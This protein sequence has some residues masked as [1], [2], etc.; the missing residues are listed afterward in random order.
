MWTKRRTL[1]G[2]S[3]AWLNPT[4]A[5]TGTGLRKESSPRPS[6]PKRYVTRRLHVKHFPQSFIVVLVD[7]VENLQR[8]EHQA[9]AMDR[10][11]VD[12]AKVA[13][14]VGGE[15]CLAFRLFDV[16]AVFE[17][18]LVAALDPFGEAL[19]SDAAAGFSQ[20]VVDDFVGEAVLEHEVDHVVDVE[21]PKQRSLP[22][23]LRGE[24]RF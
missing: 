11:D 9:G 3:P 18:V 23:Q 12:V 8:G 17:I 10:A 1:A 20:F 2:K 4:C 13:E 15:F 22:H 6:A 5:D 14:E 16:L 21:I 24:S 7:G 19:G